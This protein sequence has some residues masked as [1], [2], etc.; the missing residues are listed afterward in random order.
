[1][2]SFSAVTERISGISDPGMQVKCAGLRISLV[3]GGYFINKSLLTSLFQR[4][5]LFPSL[6]KRGKGRFYDSLHHFTEGLPGYSHDADLR[7]VR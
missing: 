3:E 1:M 4:E 5:E 2:M 7:G 6:A